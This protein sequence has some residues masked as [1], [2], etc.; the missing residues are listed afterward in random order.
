MLVYAYT[1]IFLFPFCNVATRPSHIIHMETLEEDIFC[2][3]KGD[4]G[5]KANDLHGRRRKKELALEESDLKRFYNVNQSPKGHSSE[6]KIRQGYFGQLSK[7]LM[8]KVYERYKEDFLLHG[9]QIDSFFQ[10]AAAS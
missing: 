2:F 7:E 8:T 1:I 10:Y 3:L 6:E 5:K 9:Y 4:I